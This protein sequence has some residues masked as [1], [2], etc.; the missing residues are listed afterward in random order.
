MSEEKTMSEMP[1]HPVGSRWLWLGD[2]DEEMIVVK[3]TKLSVTMRHAVE[4]WTVQFKEKEKAFRSGK[5]VR[6]TKDTEERELDD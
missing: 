4:G 6:I 2:T 5:L 1:E 3:V